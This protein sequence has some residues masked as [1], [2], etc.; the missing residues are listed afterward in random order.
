MLQVYTNTQ[1]VPTTPADITTSF[2]TYYYPFNRKVSSLILWFSDPGQSLRRDTLQSSIHLD[3]DCLYD[4]HHVLTKPLPV[5]L[6]LTEDDEFIAAAANTNI[7]MTGS[8]AIEAIK[9][10]R[11]Y[12][13]SV[14]ELL[15]KEKL[16]PEMERQL[17]ILEA[18]IAK[19]CDPTAGSDTDC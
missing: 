1:R 14:Y 3:I 6:H 11:E 18:Y 16:G 10:L 15:S 7:A 19:K 12:V 4:D 5:V 8:S 9:L 2:T 17:R 13:V